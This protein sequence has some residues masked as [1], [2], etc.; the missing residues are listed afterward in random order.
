M[1]ALSHDNWDQNGDY[2]VKMNL[3]WG[4]NGTTYKLFENDMLIDTQTLPA[5]S[6]NSQSASTPTPGK[7]AGTYRYKAE[8]SNAVGA[9]ESQ[10][11]T[12]TVQ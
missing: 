5:N 12:V 2:T 11:I 9:T 1:P 4:T 10:E 8:L 6:P 3:W 7:Q